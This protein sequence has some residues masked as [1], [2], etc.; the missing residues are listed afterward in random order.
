MANGSGQRAP[1]AVQIFFCQ[2]CGANFVL[3]P[4]ELSAT[5]AYC[6]ST[7][8]V[9]MPAKR[10]MVEPDSILP[11]GFDSEQADRYLV[12]WI[13]A[14]KINLREPAQ[15]PRGLYLPVWLFDL[16]GNLPW[17]GIRTR[18]DRKES[19]SG[20]KQLHFEDIRIL[21]SQKMAGLMQETLPEFDMSVAAAYDARFL[22]GWMA[23][24]ND[25]SMA[26]A[27][28]EARRTAVE[29]SLSLIRLEFGNVQNLDYST[30]SLMVSAFKLVL[31]PVWISGINLDSR[32]VR[33]LINGR[34][35]SIVSE[36]KPGGVMGW[37]EN[38]LGN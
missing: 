10:Q 38:V 9:A 34:T 7:H 8:V 5:C 22:S 15:P 23:D 6:G 4:N 11:M 35:G 27:S 36:H 33:L 32:L 24:V 21:G 30:A 12:D 17:K 13:K 26:D 20:E 25:L 1:V 31:V 3:A 18:N 2:G 16:M 29:R 14:Q 19:I 28:L 37:F